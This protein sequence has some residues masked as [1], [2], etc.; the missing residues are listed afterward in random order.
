MLKKDDP[1]NF[2]RVGILQQQPPSLELVSLC[3]KGAGSAANVLASFVIYSREEGFPTSTGN[4]YEG[5][6]HTVWTASPLLVQYSLHPFQ[7][8]GQLLGTTQCP[9]TSRALRGDKAFA[10]PSFSEHHR[11]C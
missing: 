10:E 9:V 2:L 5:Q 7:N 3:S 4:H 6:W 1:A 11:Q 8:P